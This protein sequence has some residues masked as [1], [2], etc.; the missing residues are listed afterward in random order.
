M[1]RRR[2]L[3][4]LAKVT[5]GVSAVVLAALAGTAWWLWANTVG[6]EPPPLPPPTPVQV[7]QVE[8]KV[9]QLETE[10][11]AAGR[12]RRARPFR[13]EMTA[14]EINAYLAHH[15]SSA[16]VR[17]L[18]AEIHPGTVVS[19]AGWVTAEGRE[20]WATATGTIGTNG[21]NLS[22]NVSDVKL[23]NVSVPASVREKFL[24][25]YRQELLSIPI[26]LPV[27]ALSVQTGEGVVVISGVSQ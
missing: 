3:S 21:P 22:L 15:S 7:A 25:R 13:L 8:T 27:A 2:R 12:A 20:V 17:E 1:P 23:G 14:Q 10:V 5:L 16:G 11:K 6:Y 9:A 18:R 26:G 4:T 24:A 19:L